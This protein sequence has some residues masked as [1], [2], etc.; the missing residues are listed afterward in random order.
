MMPL[1]EVQNPALPFDIPLDGT[2]TSLEAAYL[3]GERVHQLQKEIS[4]LQ[5]LRSEILE[6][7][8]AKNILE[9]GQFKIKKT[10]RQL[11]KID[12]DAFIH[13]FPEAALK[14]VKNV[15]SLTEADAEL[16]KNQV[17]TV[18]K[19]ETATSY[20]VEYIP[21]TGGKK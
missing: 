4:R 3:I 16:G 18:C 8:I 2:A 19:F 1:A 9:D 15:V 17:N 21:R 12:V 10:E 5:A 20:G 11:R 13:T 6:D 14:L 7:H